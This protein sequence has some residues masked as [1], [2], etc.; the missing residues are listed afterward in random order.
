MSTSDRVDGW[1]NL[2]LGL[3]LGLGLPVLPRTGVAADCHWF[4][5]SEDCAS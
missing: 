2:G 3:G 1:V 4:Q 5:W